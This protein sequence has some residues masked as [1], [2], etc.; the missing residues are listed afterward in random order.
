[1]ARI[2]YGIGTLTNDIDTA[3]NL[4]SETEAKTLIILGVVRTATTGLR[5]LHTTFGGFG[6]FNLATEQLISR[7]NLLMQ[8]YHTPSTLI[9][10]LDA[11]IGYLEL[12]IGSNQKPLTQNYNRDISLHSPGERCYGDH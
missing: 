4:L 5:R 2:R 9:R 8:H 3:N 10:K 11:S 12:Q 6:L 7:V 1:M